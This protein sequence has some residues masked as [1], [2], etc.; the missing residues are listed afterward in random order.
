M[1]RGM[2]KL[3][4]GAAALVV[5]AAVVVLFFPFGPQPGRVQDE[6]M[7]AGLKAA[8]FKPADEDYFH[9]MDGGVAFKPDEIKGRNMWLVWTGGND[10]FWDVLTQDA[11]G[12]FDLLKT[13]SSAPGL[14]YSRDTRWNYFGIVNEPCFDKPTAPDPKRY[15]L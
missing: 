9:D 1:G 13:I 4:A 15:G 7:R 5:I 14:P 12:T 2:R 6:A 8:Y 3:I 10:R 11:F